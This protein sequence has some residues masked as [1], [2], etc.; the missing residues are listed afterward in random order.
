MKR[1]LWLTPIVFGVLWKIAA[2]SWL[3]QQHKIVAIISGLWLLGALL[4]WAFFM[5]RQRWQ[6]RSDQ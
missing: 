4:I 5:G 1:V 6:Q 3:W 2:F